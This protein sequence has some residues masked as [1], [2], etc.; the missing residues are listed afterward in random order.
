MTGDE[1]V[2]IRFAAADLAARLAQLQGR[3]DTWR[4]YAAPGRSVM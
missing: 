4:N 1:R 3:V 2:R